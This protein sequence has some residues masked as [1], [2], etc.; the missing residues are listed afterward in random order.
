[1]L[2]RSY[3]YFKADVS[4]YI[5]VENHL[6]KHQT[7]FYDVQTVNEHLEFSLDREEAFNMFCRERVDIL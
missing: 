3:K 4:Q 6:V 5:S 1:M 7:D 2:L